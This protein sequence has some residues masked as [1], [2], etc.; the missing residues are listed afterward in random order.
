MRI[1]YGI[2]VWAKGLNRRHLD[3]IGVYTRNLWHSLETMGC[4]IHG[5]RFGGCAKTSPELPARHTCLKPNFHLQAAA[6]TL[7]GLPFFNTGDFE[8]QIDLFHATDHHIPKL[9]RTPVVGTIMDAIPLAHPEWVSSNLRSFK[10]FAFKRSAGWCERI[11]TISE[12]SKQDIAEHF[13]VAAERIDAIPLGVDQAFFEHASEDQIAQSLQRHGARRGSFVFVGTIQPR[14]NLRR[15]IEAHR[16]LPPSTREEHPLLVIG[17][18]GWGDEGLREELSRLQAEGRG[19]WLEDV[20]DTD[21]RPLLQSAAALI[22]PSLHEGFGLPVLEGFASNI[23]VISSNTT[24]IP[25]VAAD[26][27]LLV[28]P[29][30]VDDIAGAMERIAEDAMMARTLAQRGFERA[31]EFTWER[32]ARQTLDVYR[33]VAS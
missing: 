9:R 20:S 15:I 14:K 2:S 33:R 30:S 29:K 19:L 21:L 31:R 12:Y 4:D 27:A 18:Y 8:N 6:S 10:N 3:G 23:P 11:I 32:C 7:T 24:S 13:G 22:Y 1:G 25:E 16:N 5:L 17:R 28:D 26:A